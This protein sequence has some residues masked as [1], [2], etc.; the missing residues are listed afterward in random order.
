VI[1]QHPELR[2]F[3]ETTRSSHGQKDVSSAWHAVEL[4]PPCHSTSVDYALAAGVWEGFCEIS[5]GGSLQTRHG[6]KPG[7]AIDLDLVPKRALMQ[8][9][10]R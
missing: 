3:A 5:A 7:A 4:V 10:S 2:F 8:V 9:S 6:A 1:A